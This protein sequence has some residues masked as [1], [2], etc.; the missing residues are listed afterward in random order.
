MLYYIVI[1]R[2]LQIDAFRTKKPTNTLGRK[3]RIKNV[4]LNQ[5]NNTVLYIYIY[6]I[7]KKKNLCYPRRR[8]AQKLELVPGIGSGGH[9]DT[10]R[11][12]VGGGITRKLVRRCCHFWPTELSI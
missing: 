6:K 4:F 10:C 11:A 3:K 1:F 8:H 5:E 2:C 7:L 12:F 9:F